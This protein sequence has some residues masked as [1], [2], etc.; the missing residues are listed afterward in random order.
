MQA[1]E[2]IKHLDADTARAFLEKLPDPI[3]LAFLS[4]AAAINYPVE[5]VL[6]SAIAAAL[7]PDALSFADC[8]PQ[9]W[10]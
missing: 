8:Q 4:R 3:R 7:D 5:A 2:K 10:D 9:N 6:E 1:P